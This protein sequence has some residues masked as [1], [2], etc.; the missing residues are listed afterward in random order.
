MC[1]YGFVLNSKLSSALENFLQMF[2]LLPLLVPYVLFIMH[3]GSLIWYILPQGDTD[4]CS[5]SIPKNKVN[6][7]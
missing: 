2:S 3:P 5:K 1:V 7:A 4:D 6:V